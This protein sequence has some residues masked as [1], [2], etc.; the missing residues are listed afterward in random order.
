MPRVLVLSGPNHAFDTCAPLIAAAMR[1]QDGFE[2]TL[3]DDRD[4]LAAPDL[5]RYDVLVHGSGFTSRER[6]PDGSVATRPY[7]TPEQERG[8]F[9]FVRSGK[10]LLG[11]HGTG[12]WIGGEAIDL[13]GGH[14]NWHPPGLEFE[15][16]VED[17][18]HPIT[19]G[20][21]DFRVRDEIYMSAWD[22]SIHVLA[23]ATWADRK[24]PMAW[25]HRY[26]NGRVFFTTLG[27]GPST[28]ENAA[29]Q[30]L[31]GNAARWASSG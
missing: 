6:Q 18:D 28:F 10:G 8:V 5:H 27:H 16:H 4:V 26:G 25:T 17:A 1:D 9:D 14:A 7:L 20:L 29:V 2:V 24:H 11:I 31:L 21:A 12:W 3:S 30:K 22:P 19:R 13:L 15:V 23:T